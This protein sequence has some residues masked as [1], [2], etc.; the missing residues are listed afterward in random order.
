VRGSAAAPS[1][2]AAAAPVDEAALRREV[3]HVALMR[4]Q[5]DANPA[6]VLTLGDEARRIFGRGVLA[7]E[8]EALEVLA[9]E[10]LGRRS[11]V[12]ARG[13]AYLARFPRGPFS[14][15]IRRVVQGEL[16]P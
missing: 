4:K 16:R 12:A 8:R 10:R 5:L 6:A 15:R 14:E 3:S 2:P 7:E 1:P 13:A 9:L 11:D